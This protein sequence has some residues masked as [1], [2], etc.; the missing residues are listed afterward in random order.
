MKKQ[1]A[2]NGF[3]IFGKPDL[4]KSAEAEGAACSPTSRFDPLL[5]FNKALELSGGISRAHAYRLIPPRQV[6]S[7]GPDLTAPHRHSHV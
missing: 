1:A 5:P 2:G 3:P 4:L 7:A 6:P